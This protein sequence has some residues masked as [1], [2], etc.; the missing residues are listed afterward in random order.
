MKSYCVYRWE[1]PSKDFFFYYL[2][3]SFKH[4]RGAPNTFYV[5]GNVIEEKDP[6]AFFTHHS[7][8]S[9]VDLLNSRRIRRRIKTFG[10]AIGRRHWKNNYLQG[11][12]KNGNTRAIVARHFKLKSLGS[13][14]RLYS[15]T[16]VR[17]GPSLCIL[18]HFV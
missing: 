14:Q 15:A 11:I 4:H 1:F 7:E 2:K 6:W 17:R 12:L 9:L 8:S 5:E 10:E 13:K 18:L 3:Q 16:I